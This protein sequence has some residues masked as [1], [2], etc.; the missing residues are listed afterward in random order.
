MDMRLYIGQGPTDI[1]VRPDDRYPGMWRVHG[2]G[3]VSDMVNLTR[4]K[5]A[6]IAWARP[7]G[8]GTPKHI[9]WERRETPGNGGSI[10]FSDDQVVQEPPRNETPHGA[11]YEREA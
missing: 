10:R 4:A 2:H 7:D 6:A 8:Q 5:D 1:F 3:R 11:S 9:S